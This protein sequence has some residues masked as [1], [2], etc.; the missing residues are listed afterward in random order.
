MTNTDQIVLTVL[1]QEERDLR[2]R[3]I[4]L[5]EKRDY[6]SIVFHDTGSGTVGDSVRSGLNSRW[7]NCLRLLSGLI[8]KQWDSTFVLK[9]LSSDDPILKKIHQ[10]LP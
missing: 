4:E 5:A 3:I 9:E 10:A 1:D 6:I 7:L 2:A 8:K